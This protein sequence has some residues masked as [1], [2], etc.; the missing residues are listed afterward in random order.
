MSIACARHILVETE[1][2]CLELKKQIEEGRLV[3]L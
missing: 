1:Q 2:Q 3:P